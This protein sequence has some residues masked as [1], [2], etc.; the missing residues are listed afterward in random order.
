MGP[1]WNLNGTEIGPKWDH[2]ETK[3]DQMR[4]KYFPVIKLVNYPLISFLWTGSIFLSNEDSTFGKDICYLKLSNVFESGCWIK[5][6]ETLCTHRE[7]PLNSHF[8]LSITIRLESLQPCTKVC[9]WLLYFHL[10]M[11]GQY[12]II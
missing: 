2:N 12:V 3:R 8:T 4:P 5:S 7:E 6:S 10:S 11:I 1:K 9:W